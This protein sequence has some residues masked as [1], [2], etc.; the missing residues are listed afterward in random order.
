MSEALVWEVMKSYSSKSLRRTHPVATF[1]REKG[2]LCHKRTFR[3]SGL[4]RIKAVDVTINDDG[5]PVLSIKNSNPEEA[6]LPDK[7]WREV[8]LSGGVRK[9]LATTD[10]LLADYKPSLKK[11]A[12]RKVSAAY[13]AAARKNKSAAASA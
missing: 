3:D 12:M 6:R 8:T 10:T 4:A 2:S 1:T 11:P 5:I 9:A 7:M 13:M